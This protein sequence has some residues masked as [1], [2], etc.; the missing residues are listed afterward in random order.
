[1]ENRPKDIV[2]EAKEKLD[3]DDKAPTTLKSEVVKVIK[4]MRRH[5]TTGDD[6][7]SV[8]LLKELGD[9]GLKIMT[10]LVNKIYMR[11]AKGFS[12]CYN[13]CITKKKPSK[14]RHRPQNN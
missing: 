8:D 10:A 14:E 1:M 6:D 5:K 4:D 9:S 7:M 11:L 13:D 12:R 2:I 3:E